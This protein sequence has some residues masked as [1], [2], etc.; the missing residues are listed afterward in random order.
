MKSSTRLSGDITV[1]GGKP[2]TTAVVEL[3]NADGDVVDQVR[4]DDNGFYRYYVSPGKWSLKVWDGHGHS[5]HA[6]VTIAEGEQKVFDL[7]LDEP[8]GGH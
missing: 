8:A 7:D 6:E 4:V 1:H 5:A 2:A 3:H